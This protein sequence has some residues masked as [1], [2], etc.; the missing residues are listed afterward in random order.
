MTVKEHLKNIHKESEV[1]HSHKGK[2][3]EKLSQAHARL[4]DQL[5]KADDGDEAACH[6]ELSEIHK[7]MSS[8][9]SENAETSRQMGALLDTMTESQPY[10]VRKSLG[11]ASDSD[12]IVPDHVRMVIGPPEDLQ[13]VPRRGQPAIDMQRVAPQFRKFVET[14]DEERPA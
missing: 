12:A 10:Q 4:A 14:E 7:A 9:E 8:L 11:L 13:A 1:Y 6:R 3:H 5:T 2:H